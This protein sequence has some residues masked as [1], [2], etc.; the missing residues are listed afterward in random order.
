ML[1]YDVFQEAACSGHI[2]LMLVKERLEVFLGRVRR[3]LEQVNTFLIFLFDHYYFLELSSSRRFIFGPNL[4]QKEL[5]KR[6]EIST[7]S[8]DRCDSN[9]AHA[10]LLLLNSSRFTES[11]N[12]VPFS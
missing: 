10:M 7:S 6:R 4:C 9:C 2:M 8:V 12:N 11:I 1:V 5:E 3:N